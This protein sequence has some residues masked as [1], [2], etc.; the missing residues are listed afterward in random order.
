VQPSFFYNSDW[1]NLN[2]WTGFAPGVINPDA[3]RMPEPLFIMLVYPFGLLTFAIGTNAVMRFVAGRRP[4]WSALKLL[5]AGSFAAILAG[6]ALEAPMFLLHL[7]AL[8]GAPS[9]VSL[10]D[11][12][13][14][15][16]VLPA[17][18]R[19]RDVQRRCDPAHSLRAMPWC[20]GLPPAA[21][22]AG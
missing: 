1:L 7:W 20:S 16:G 21:V 17:Q 14:R 2:S 3:S 4:Q 18:S 8:P 13:H 6:I 5:A 22:A 9:S 12:A 19:Q 11:N 10:F 15:Y